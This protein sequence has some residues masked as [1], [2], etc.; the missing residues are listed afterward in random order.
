[1]EKKRFF[2]RR[3][4][5]VSLERQLELKKKIFEA[6]KMTRFSVC[7]VL[8]QWVW[9]LAMSVSKPKNPMSH[10]PNTEWAFFVAFEI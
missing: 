9:F 8:L 5:F 7:C 10:I 1:M 3:S 2:G 4:R 6:E